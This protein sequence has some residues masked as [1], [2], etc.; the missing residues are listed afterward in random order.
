MEGEIHVPCDFGTGSPAKA[1]TTRV[2]LDSHGGFRSSVRHWTL[3]GM[4]IPH[5]AYPDLL[6]GCATA[7]VKG[8]I[9][10]PIFEYDHGVALPSS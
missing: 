3:E 8:P 2:L 9:E 5:S 1:A 4:P 10:R 6:C 7:V